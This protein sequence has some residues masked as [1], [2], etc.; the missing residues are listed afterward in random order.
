MKKTV[1]ILAIKKNRVLLVQSKGKTNWSLPGG[2]HEKRESDKKC[3]QRECEEEL[4]RAKIVFTSRLG[5]FE[6]VSHNSRTPVSSVVFC[7][8]VKGRI[9]PGAEI[10]QSAWFSKEELESV[11]VS[12]LTLKI[13]REAKFC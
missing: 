13:L 11:I 1:N 6:G 5:K 7:A 12:D 3:V 2:K 8:E 4:P 9:T 10:G